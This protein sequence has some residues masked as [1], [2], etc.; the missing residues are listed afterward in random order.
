MKK[1]YSMKKILCLLFIFIIASCSSP[2]KVISQKK[3]ST[4]PTYKRILFVTDTYY[5]HQSLIKKLFET[6][7]KNSL[8]ISRVN[9]KIVNLAKEQL[10][11]QNKYASF[12]LI[13]NNLD[14]RLILTKE[15]IQQNIDE[16]VLD[17]NIDLVITIFQKDIQRI[18]NEVNTDETVSNRERKF[19]GYNATTNSNNLE[20]TYVFTGKDVNK[21][22]IVLKTEY[23]VQN[24]DDLLSNLPKRVS[25]NLINILNEKHLY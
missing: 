4:P 12:Y 1:N 14:E 8:T 9:T 18:Y 10:E 11:E 7:L 21:D 3:D 5:T 22:T 6:S 17:K 13:K 15:E 2:K 20:Y 16:E 23:G 25:E 19:L 24:A